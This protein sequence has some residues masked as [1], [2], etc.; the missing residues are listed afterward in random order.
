M[1]HDYSLFKRKDK[2]AWYVYYYDKNGKRVSKSTGQ[3]VKY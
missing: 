3:T 1:R 2:K